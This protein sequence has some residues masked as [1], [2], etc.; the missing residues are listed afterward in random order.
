[1]RRRLATAAALSLAL[2]LGAPAVVGAAAPRATTGRRH[3]GR[4]DDRHGHGDGRARRRGDDLDRRVRHDHRLRAEDERAQRRERHRPGRRLGAADGAGR[5]ASRST[6]ASSRPTT[7]ARRG[8]RTGRSAPVRLRR[9]RSARRARSGRP[10]LSCPAPSTRT[11]SR[12]PGTS[13]YGTSRSYGSRSATADAG[14][15]HE[16]AHGLGRSHRPAARGPP[17]TSGSSPRTPPARPAAASG[18]SAPTRARA[19]RR[20]RRATWVARPPGSAAPSIPRAGTRSRGSSTAA[21]TAYGSRTPERGV[22]F[23]TRSTTVS[24][25]LTGLPAGTTIHYRIVARS[26]AGTSA[27]RDRTFRTTDGPAVVTGP[28]T[29]V[30]PT[31]ATATGS[32]RPA[33]PQHEL[34]VRVR[35]D[36]AGTG[37]GRRSR[38]A[39]S[40]SGPVAGDRA[41]H[42]AA[43]R[44]PS[45]TSASSRRARPGATLRR[46]RRLPHERGPARGHRAA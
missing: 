7:T 46:G 21:T 41:P 24:E 43:A 26:D 13:E 40:G 33:G 9:S 45:S 44:R 19:C 30:G 8:E 15:G 6:T 32:R 1:M 2:A 12:R 39:G 5:P 37:R 31:S 11:A 18:A 3:V 29:E 25:T 22:G 35:H 27:G 14:L 4:R 38:R 20:A 10:A 17:T 23:G 42:R 34:V 16:R 28:V 36:D